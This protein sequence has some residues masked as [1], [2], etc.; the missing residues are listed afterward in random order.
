MGDN[1]VPQRII[2]VLALAGVGIL[3]AASQQADAHAVAGN[4]VFPVTLTMDDPGVSD[5]ASVPTFQYQRDDSSGT[6]TDKYGWNFEY[7]K[8]VT[9][10]FGLGLNWGYNL[11]SVHGGKTAGG[12]QNLTLTA[13]YQT[14]VNAPHEFIMSLGVVREFGGTGNTNQG[15]DRFG[16]TEPTIYMGKGLGDLPIGAL[17]AFAVTGELGYNFQD[18]K[19]N[20]TNDNQ[21]GQNGVDAAISIQYSMPYLQSQVKDYGLPDFFN[22]LIPLVE[23]TWN[24]PTGG[25]L[26]PS[27]T[28]FQIAPGVIYMADTWEFGVEALIPGN[29]AAGTHVGVIAMFHMFF[30]D[31]FPN[32]LGK[33]LVDW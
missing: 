30:D 15:A 19:Q 8:T 18:V 17:R 28:T 3:T 11:N 5:E 2:P 6:P 16:S 23:L 10:N 22:H 1:L 7:D 26:T 14:Y 4:R 13:K 33:P 9:Q 32:S 20:S 24:V 29:T 25:V 31:M 27:P 21:G 12:F